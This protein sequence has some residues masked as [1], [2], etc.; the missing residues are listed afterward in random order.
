MR[1]ACH[2]QRLE[3]FSR[4]ILSLDLLL[5]TSNRLDQVFWP[6]LLFRLLRNSGRH[7]FSQIKGEGLQGDE[8]TLTLHL[9]DLA[10]WLWSIITNYR[11]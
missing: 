3:F 8:K 1:G 6:Y 10:L 9:G 2:K 7:F 11:R 4:P 5:I